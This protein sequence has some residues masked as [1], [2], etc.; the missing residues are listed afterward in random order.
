MFENYKD[1]EPS[2]TKMGN[3]S[4]CIDRDAPVL[5]R[6]CMVYDHIIFSKGKMKVYA[7]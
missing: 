2:S 1:I 3:I 5:L 7:L 6:Y 4:M